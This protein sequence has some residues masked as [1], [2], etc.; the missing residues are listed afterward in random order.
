[1]E[2]SEKIL[3]LS[4]SSNSE[5]LRIIAAKCLQSYLTVFQQ[6]KVEKMTIILQ[7]GFANLLN[8]SLSLLQDEEYDVRQIASSFANKLPR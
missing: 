4:E 8:A 3:Q 1:M 5:D 7:F 6:K 2:N